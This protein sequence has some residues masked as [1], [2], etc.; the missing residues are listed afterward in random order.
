MKPCLSFEEIPVKM[1]SRFGEAATPD[2]FGVGSLQNEVE[3]DLSETDELYEGYGKRKNSYP[4]RQQNIYS[5][6]L[7]DCLL[8]AAILE[9]DYLKAVFLPS[10][11]GRLWSLEDKKNGRNLL[12]TNDVIRFSNLAVRNAWFS[13]GVEWNIGVMGHTPFTND[14]LYTARLEDELGNPVLRMYE[15]ERIRNVEYQMDFF[16]REDSHCLNCRMRI[17][18]HSSEVTPMYWWSNMAV[19]EYEGGRIVVPAR[20]AYVYREHRVGREE[21]PMVAGKDIFQYENIEK[22]VD[23]FF[24]IPEKEKKY[25]ANIDDRGYGLLQ[26][27]TARLKSRKLFSWGHNDG[28]ERWQEFLTDEAGK[29]VEIQAGLNKTQYGC[30]PMAPHTAWEWMEQ[31]G[32]VSLDNFSAEKSFDEIQEKV[33]QTVIDYWHQAAPDELLWE[34]EQMAKSKGDLVYA[35]SAHGSLKRKCLALSGRE[36]L[37][38]H[39]DY[40]DGPE[41][42]LIREFIESGRLGKVDPDMRPACFVNDPLIISR[43]KESLEGDNKDHWY[44]YYLLGIWYLQEEKYKKAKKLLKK[45]YER[46]ENAWSLHGLACLYLIR[47]DLD[48]SKKYIIKGMEMRRED[49]SYIKEGIQILMNLK[50]YAAVLEIYQGLK[51]ELQQE[52][53]IR[54]SYIFSLHFEGETK[55]AYDLLCQGDGYVLDDIREGADDLGL[56]WKD[57]YKTLYGEEKPVPYAFNFV[58]L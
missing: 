31:Y 15:Y 39:L 34:T 35:G 32:P 54:Y 6:E 48:K 3:F 5:R 26:M 9:N 52:S 14:Q 47:G 55:Q 23:Y 20:E 17:F 43:L 36:S 50:E 28:S 58:S 13:G 42:Q 56:L 10:L 22:Q 29:Y 1:S 40:Q 37:S 30:I 51:P 4:Y 16:L 38:Q 18:N 24:I 11:G 53:R 25:I 2:I 12:Y 46:R 44:A 49:L 7:K 21:V 27:S 41:T 57:M 8:K 19:P 45:S 33:Q